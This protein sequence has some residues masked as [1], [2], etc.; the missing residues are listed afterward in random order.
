MKKWLIIAFLFSMGSIIG[1]ILEVLFRRFF[2][3]ANPE[4]KWLNPGFL[5]GPYLPLYGFSLCMI[6][7]LSLINVSLIHDPFLQD[8]VLFVLM[9]FSITAIEYVAGLIF[10]KGLHVKLWDYSHEKWNIQGIICSKFT[11]FWYILSAFYYFLIHPKIIHSIE[12]LSGHLTFS[13]FIGVFYGVFIIDL[14]YSLKVLKYIKQYAKEKEVIVHYEQL[15]A[16]IDELRNKFHEKQRFL[17]SFK[18][19][20]STF[21]EVLQHF[22]DEKSR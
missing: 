10:I 15:R 11:F 4:R 8:M 7:F 17:F 14:C 21:K 19:D 18:L 16:H 12:W 6:Y 22:I 1:W 3:S 13:F 2:S 20:H 5:V 9:A